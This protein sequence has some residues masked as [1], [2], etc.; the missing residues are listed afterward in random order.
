MKKLSISFLLCLVTGIFT[1]T[2]CLKDDD[3]TILPMGY[4]TFINSYP[5]A[6]SIYYSTDRGT[7]PLPYKSFSPATMLIGNRNIAVYAYGTNKAILDTTVT[8]KDSMAYSSFIFGTEAAPRFA[9][10]QDKS[11]ENLGMN[12]GFRFLNLAN[13]SEEINLI[14]GSET[15]ATFTNR[16]TETGATAVAHQEFVAKSSGNMTLKITDADGTTL[17]TRESYSF[18][19]GYY[20]TIML[21]GKKDDT[22]N[23]LYIG[24]VAH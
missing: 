5:D 20:Y 3:S 1:F 6:S 2:S 9:M 7:I 18:R 24:I 19:Q 15:T 21:S 4:M 17:A 11:I 23:P 8:I 22:E 13:D 16:A 14:I 12:S 10:T